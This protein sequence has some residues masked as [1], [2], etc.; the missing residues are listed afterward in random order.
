VACIDESGRILI[1]KQLAGPFAGSWLLPGG[2]VERNERP[3]DA[4]RR[5]LLEESG[6]RV[7]ALEP[8]ALYDVRSVP[9]GG[10]HFL[11]HLFRAGAVSGAPRPEVGG[12][13]LW[14][15]PRAIDAHPNLALTLADLG[16]ID[17][18]RVSIAE[19]LAKIGVTMRR[20]L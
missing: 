3:E 20:V 12:E 10:F 8:V 15:D 17:R 18:D 6:Y 2:S 1:V 5:E 9:T 19:D 11:V 14:G 7:A 13:L 4:A 16:L